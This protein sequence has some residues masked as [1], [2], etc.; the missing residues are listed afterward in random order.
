MPAMRGVGG[1]RHRR[2]RAAA[3]VGALD[4]PA[5]LRVK[6]PSALVADHLRHR[7]RPSE[8]GLLQCVLLDCSAS[9]RA[10]Q[11]LALAKGL[12]VA[13]FEHA[14]LQRSEVALICFDGNGAALRV[15]PSRVPG[16]VAGAVAR[17]LQ[18]IGG[19]GGTP[20]AAAAALAAQTLR[21]AALR[22]PA[23][24]R[25]LWVFTDARTAVLPPRPA[26]ADA[27]FIVDFEQGTL[28]LGRAARLAERWQAQCI[29]ADAL[30]EALTSRMRDGA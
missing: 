21:R 25:E 19:G 10:G 17:W 12:L 4:W 7:A 26:A 11:R 2:G 8:R 1:R 27:A 13:L 23:Q 16:G 24:L 28:R 18:P 20:L 22:R 3:P 6:G 29:D 15:P 5:T 30:R 14:Y 9:M